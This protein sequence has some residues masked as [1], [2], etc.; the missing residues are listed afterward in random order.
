M[1]SCK[2]TKL[3]NVLSLFKVPVLSSMYKDVTVVYAIVTAH[4]GKISAKSEDGNSLTFSILLNIPC[5]HKKEK[6]ILTQHAESSS[7][8]HWIFI[9]YFKNPK[10]LTIAASFAFP[11]QTLTKLMIR[12]TSKMIKH[13]AAAIGTT[14]VQQNTTVISPSRTSDTSILIILYQSQ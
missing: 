11:L 4:K 2:T 9:S 6:K 1:L 8:F 14:T 12:T 10:L 13:T 5:F 7:L 3:T